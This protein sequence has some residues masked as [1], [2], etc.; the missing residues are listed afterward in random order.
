MFGTHS[1]QRLVC[2]KPLLSVREMGDTCGVVYAIP[3]THYPMFR[4]VCVLVLEPT[5][6]KQAPLRY[7]LQT[8]PQVWEPGNVPRW[9]WHQRH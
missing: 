6:H 9:T 2:H 7:P 5:V 3:C 1:E 4:R 8:V